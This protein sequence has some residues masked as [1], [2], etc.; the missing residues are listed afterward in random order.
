MNVV[1][2]PSYDYLQPKS[3]VVTG[4]VAD[5]AGSF[6]SSLTKYRGRKNNF[7]FGQG[8]FQFTLIRFLP[9]MP[10]YGTVD[11]ESNPR[12]LTHTHTLKWYGLAC[13]GHCQKFWFSNFL[14]YSSFIF[15]VPSP[16]K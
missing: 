6:S 1:V 14:L 12:P 5:R 9:E 13:C 10:G 8:S 3:L 4:V 15:I 16:L 11:A 7:P 2:F